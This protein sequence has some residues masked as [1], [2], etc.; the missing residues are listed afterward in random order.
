VYVLSVPAASAIPMSFF[1]VGTAAVIGAAERWRRKELQPLRGLAFGLC[2]MGGAFIGA[3]L[4]VLVPERVRLALFGIAVIASAASMLAS[5]QRTEARGKPTPLW[6]DYVMF[7]GI[8]ILTSIIG[9]GGGVLFVP[10]LVVVVGLPLGEAAG[11]SLM[12]IAMNAA[13]SFAGSYGQVHLEWRLLLTF[14]AMVVVA[15]LVAG[16][17]APRIPVVAL[18][19]AFAVV[20]LA[21]GA[22]VLLENLR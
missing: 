17:V 7:I 12:L 15:T 3:R 20:V 19:R 10:A 2:A 18:K 9:I 6:I 1:V 4:A 5:A 21:I 11:L 16:R 8:G 13:A 14:T 22:L